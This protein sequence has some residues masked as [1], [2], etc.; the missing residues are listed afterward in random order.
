[1][2]RLS[3]S[4]AAALVLAGCASFSPDG[5]AGRVAELTKERKRAK[6]DVLFVDLGAQ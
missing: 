1:M 5:G 3:A 4:A 6:R 2:M